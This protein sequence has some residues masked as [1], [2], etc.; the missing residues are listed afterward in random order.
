MGTL[1]FLKSGTY[2][3]PADQPVLKK[4]DYAMLLQTEAVLA[5]ARI[6]AERIR[7]DAKRAYEE[8][9]KRGYEDGMAE[10]KMEMTER[11][12]D[13]VSAGVNYLENLEGAI[14][15]L[16]LNSLRKIVEGF[17]D[18]ERV[19]GVV[20]RGLGYVRNQKRVVLRLPP[21]DEE[22]VRAEFDALRRDFPGIAILDLAPD[23]R[24]PNGSCV[25]ESELGLIDASLEVQMAGIRRSF[26]RQFKGKAGEKP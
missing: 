1:L 22:R 8:E 20:R 4:G 18:R 15:D 3:P 10:G 6:E 7:E 13:T 9:K 14:V 21:E 17:D 11:M 25:L 23:P 5:H 24:L 19:M 2:T 26:L 12:L 16:V